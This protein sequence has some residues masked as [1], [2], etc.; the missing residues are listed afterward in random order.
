MPL[1]LAD[2]IAQLDAAPVDFDPE[3]VGKDDD[4][5]TEAAA[6]REHY[7]DVGPS[8]LRN[9]VLDPKYDG[10]RTTRKSLMEESEEDIEEYEEEPSESEHEDEDEEEESESEED[11]LKLEHESKSEVDE[12]E[13]D[14]TAELKR[15]REDDKRKGIAVSRQIAI[16]DALLEARIRMQKAV[17]AANS[18]PKPS[19]MDVYIQQPECRQALN[20]M[21]DEALLLADELD[22]LQEHLLTKNES[23][24]LPPRKRRKLDDGEDVD[25]NR[26]LEDATEDVSAVEHAMHPW[27]I[28]TLN[29]WSAKIQAVAPSMLLP[30]NR[31]AFSKTQQN[32]KSAVQLAEETLRDHDKLLSRSRIRRGKERR[33]G[34]SEEGEETQEGEEE[35]L[36]IFDDTDFYQQLLRD[37]IESKGTGGVDD[38]MTVQKEKKAKKKVDTKAS[39]GRKI[40]YHVHEKIQNFMVP[41]HVIGGWHEEQIDELFASLLGKGFESAGPGLDEEQ[42]ENRLDEGVMTGFQV[43]G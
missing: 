24:T 35:D 16:W 37:V 33:L 12:Q 14:V 18:L 1:S 21:L 5:L 27:S 19:D 23:I 43:F 13:N 38:W 10:Q 20:N 15:K 4:I 9:G 3:D 42:L 11:E 25:Y 30:S 31:N 17:N 2:Q 28:Q 36:D 41:V 29:K 8:T 39:K 32:V 26:Q 6:A 34:A 22:D 40:R 7:M